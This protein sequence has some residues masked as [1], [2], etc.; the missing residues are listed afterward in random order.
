MADVKPTTLAE[1]YTLERGTH[2]LS[3]ITALARL[4]VDQMR[5]DRRAG[6][7]TAG[8]VSGYPGSPLGGYDSEL[9][10][11]DALLK[12]HGIVHQPGLN[13]EL[14]A[15]A[16]YGSQV[17]TTT[18]GARVEGVLGVWYG[19]APGVDRA[20]DALRHGNFSGTGPR[21]GVLVLAGDDPASK[22]STLPSSSERTLAELSMPVFHPADTQD[23]LDLGHHAVAASRHSGL[24]AGFK[25]VTVV[26]D[27]SG[28]VDL[29]LDRVSVVVPEV[30]D[31]GLRGPW[32]R[33]NRD[34]SVGME[35]EMVERRIPR[36]RA[37]GRVNRL[38]DVTVDAGSGAWLG[39]VAPG[40]TY[41]DVLDACRVLGLGPAELAALGVRILRVRMPW[42]I[43]P[44]VIREF[45][46]GLDEVVVVEEK[47]S[48][49]ETQVKEALYGVAAAPVVTG[50]ADPDGQALV[51]AWGALDADRLA[52]PLA[53]RLLTRVDPG[54][55]DLPPPPPRE[56][57]HLP[58]V[59]ARP[60]WFCSGCPHLTS[61][62]VPDG[63]LVGGGIGCHGLASRMAVERTGEL[64]SN[65]QMGGEG[66]QWVGAAPFLD[67]GHLFQNVG[68]GTLFHSGWLA[69]RFA[70]AAG[71]H[72]TYKILYNDAVA[73]TG[74]QSP[75]GAHPVPELLRGLRAEGVGR[76]IVTTE[77]TGRYR[78]VEL[79]AGV[80]VW[81][82]G[83]IVEAQEALAAESGVT[84]L[85]H[86]QQCA[87]ELRRD[88]KRGREPIPKERVAIVERV[89]EGCGDCGA[90]S[91]CLSLHP[92]DTF[93]GPRTEIH[94][95]SCNLDLSCLQGDCPS[96]VLTSERRLRLP[97]S[98]RR[99]SAGGGG[100]RTARPA[101]PSDLP[102][103]TVRAGG[104]EVTV[105]M[106]G[107]GGTGVV[108][109]AQV[110]GMAATLDGWSV[111]G[112]D[113]TGL[114]QKAGPVVSELR[115]SRDGEARPGHVSSAG[116]DLLLAF[117]LLV[118]LSPEH[119]RGL[120]PERTVGVVST[121]ITPTGFM[122]GDPTATLPSADTLAD[123]LRPLLATASFVDAEDLCARVVGGTQSANVLLLGVAYQLGALPVSAASLEQALEL[124]GVAVD[125]NLAAFRWG[126]ALVAR[127][128]SIPT[129]EVEPDATTMPVTAL[130]DRLAGDLRRYQDESYAGRFRE[131]VDQVRA[132]DGDGELARSVA[133]NLHKLM[134]YK[135]EYEVAALHLADPAAGGQRRVILLH[136]PILRALGLKRKLRFGPGTRPLLRALA[137]GRRLRGTRLDPFGY[138]KVRRVERALVDEYVEVVRRLVARHDQLDP[139]EAVRIAELPQLVRG[140]E[141]VKLAN[142]ARYRSALA[143]SGVS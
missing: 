37:Y 54:R 1:R 34:F 126:R 22:S 89:C 26:A 105:R 129:A 43:D 119:L 65:T 90:K 24:W 29:D 45:A 52:G 70:V 49:V 123:G 18:D 127:P 130:V 108:T 121:S 134:A 139:A 94:Q 60:A 25:V 23:L 107:I 73:M 140:Y 56:R 72:I 83:R 55:I 84:V 58:V 74:G 92:V 112:V 86:D 81:D 104:G 69:V 6:W 96:F 46:A 75:T 11:I 44:S 33:L 98:R 2:Y 50:R 4:P 14:A 53:S 103:P 77:D 13:E 35:Q 115:L 136:P 79:P 122:V 48:F 87:A 117:D 61:T 78:G 88:R 32:G 62:R 39:I 41:L 133:R 64:L 120:D 36:A 110:V 143:E 91:A 113:Q 135:D 67:R 38:N 47:R 95:T 21:S 116:V 30:D 106:P 142:V 66:A 137:A 118:A 40:H 10:R 28:D 63:A 97:W 16:V 85:L 12:E 93:F 17:A 114:S 68:D 102:E 82:R 100:S 111:D 80:E 7:R 131:V 71:S 124:N 27:G 5:L 51:P 15:T 31:G 132:V 138:A 125:A 141:H 42:P 19:K 101:P 76:I 59:P 57:L 128:E 99:S 8:F 9:G 3:G 109:V 20:A